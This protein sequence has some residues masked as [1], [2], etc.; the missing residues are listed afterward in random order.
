MRTSWLAV[1]AII[2][3]SCATKSPPQAKVPLPVE[4]P[5]TWQA[6]ETITNAP[7]SRWWE[8][9]NNT[10]L[11][12]LVE[13]AWQNN[14]DLRVAVSRLEASSVEARLAGADR[15]PKVDLGFDAARRQQNF[16]GLPIPG[17]AG[18]V[19]KSRST[20]F[21]LNLSASWEVD[22][23]GRV[24]A[25][26]SAATADFEA[27]SA[28]VAGAELSLAAQTV[29]AW[30][31]AAEAKQQL[32]LAVQTATSYRTTAE[33]VRT[34]Y[35]Q[36]LRSPLDLRQALASAA[37]AEAQRE[38]RKVQFERAVR[39]LEVLLGRYPSGKLEGDYRLP[40]LP[41]EVPAGV[42]A[43][44]VSRR[45]DLA[46]A[47]RRIA[48]AGERVKQSK[49]ALYPRISLTA[50]GGTSTRD[51][52]DL[53]TRN[54]SVWSIAANAVQPLFEGGKLRA[55][56]ELNKVRE[57][58]AQLEF[59][60]TA[61]NAFGEVEN[62]LVGEKLW[63]EREARLQEAKEQSAAALRLAEE[64]Y[65]QGLETFT[66]VLDSQRRL[67]EAESQLLALRRQRLD[68][69]VDLHVALGGGF[70]H[71]VEVKAKAETAKTN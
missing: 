18:T 41:G 53:L 1:V 56:V 12:V 51:L 10:N 47:E 29:K 23:W 2:G 62:A 61:L 7:S 52:E 46:A 15:M 20:S 19:L 39:R 70:E 63:N 32:D 50:S 28:D 3:T 6:A 16:I 30:L 4:A 11:T 37:S 25:G 17:G 5:A 34:R 65:F 35:E 48:A 38:E 67:F 49:A 60:D 9:F 54:F 64:R 58:T 59:V 40:S 24:R 68:N 8:S 36:G 44:I 14:R 55:N 71:V 27:M 33:Q 43:E 13:E 31:G 22:L 42:P 21:G 66:T 57:H 45:P 69:R 26:Q